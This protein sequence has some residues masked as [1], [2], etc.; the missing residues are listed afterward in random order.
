MIEK[1]QESRFLCADLVRLDWLAG[2]NTLR[3]EQALLEDIS[4]M[5]GCVQLEEPVELGSAVMLT[6][7]TT[8]FYGHVCYCTLRDEGYFIGLRFSNE[9]VWSA[10]LARPR[11]LTNLQQLGCELEMSHN[12]N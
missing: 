5:G 6:L 1:R 9:T 11:H 2:K 4:P 8:P 10:S 7:G 3:T 12:G